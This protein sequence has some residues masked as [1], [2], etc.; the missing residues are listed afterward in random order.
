MTSYL[1]GTIKNF[2]LTLILP[3]LV[4][5]KHCSFKIHSLQIF[6]SILNLLYSLPFSCVAL[7]V[8]DFMPFGHIT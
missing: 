4:L 1:L 3:A 5:E 6:G 8:V 2:D 7:Y